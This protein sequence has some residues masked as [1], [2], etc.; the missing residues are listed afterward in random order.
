ML[1]VK[2]IEELSKKGFNLFPISKSFLADLETPLSAFLKLKRLGAFMLLE[3]VEGGEKWGR[4]SI[5]GLGNYIT[6]K[7]KG[8]FGE[9]N[10]LGRVEVGKHEDPL[11]LLRD[12]FNLSR[13][14]I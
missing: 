12:V 2:E 1:E 4:F 14:H 9:I 10:R 8:E 3:S 5:I 11:E 6:V 13:I 7:S